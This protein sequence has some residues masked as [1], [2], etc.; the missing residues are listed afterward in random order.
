V[1]FGLVFPL[2]LFV[3]LGIMD[4]GM[5]F[6]QYEVLTNAAREGARVAV[7]PGYN[8]STDAP[9]RVQQ[10]LAASFLSGGGAW[11]I[12]APTAANV[13]ING[14]C[15]TVIT[16]TVTYPH[17]FIFLA[18]IGKYFNATFGTKT[19]TASST[20]RAEVAAASCP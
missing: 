7:L 4:F 18:G 19:L 13:L 1:E 12:K 3:V 14:N 8:P 16:V 15:M 9:A 2:L 17:Q 20:M 10:Y 6:Q 5:M 11:T